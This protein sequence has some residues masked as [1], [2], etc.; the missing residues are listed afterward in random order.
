MPTIRP[1]FLVD[2]GRAER[3]SCFILICRFSFGPAGMVSRRKF[4]RIEK[5]SSIAMHIKLYWTFF[6]EAIDHRNQIYLLPN[7]EKVMCSELA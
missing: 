2:F 3:E 5:F 7:A 1:D 4:N 6:R